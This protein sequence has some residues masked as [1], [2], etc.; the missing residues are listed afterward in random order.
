MKTSF[1]PKCAATAIGSMP[2]VDPKDA[3]SFIFS[4][5]PEMPMWPQLN[6]RSWKESMTVQFCEGMPSIVVDEENERIYF[7][8]GPEADLPGQVE[9]FYVDYLSKCPERFQIS[10]DY[11]AGLQAFL[12]TL[13]QLPQA[14]KAYLKGHV[15]GPVTFGLSVTDEN[16]QAVLYNEMLRDTV[17]KT[18]ALKAAWQVDMF[19]RARPGARAVIFFD[20]PY[21]QSF[22]SAYV[23]LSREEVTAI[24]NE[25][26][27]A[28]DG[29][30]GVHC[31]GNTDWSILM[32][33]DV[34]IISFDAYD[35]ID[36]LVLYPEKLSAFLNRG[37]ALAWGIVPSIFPDPGQVAH[38]DVGSLASRFAVGLE[39]ITA[40]GTSEELVINQSLLTPT[41]GTGSME[42]SLAERSISLTAQ[43]SQ[44]LRERYFGED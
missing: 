1:K 13:E 30:T 20:E 5:L 36:N 10:A 9:A 44:E 24:L 35:Y 11:A 38:E 17:V 25:C 3:C 37:G 8:T 43:L 42:I 12:N 2:Y 22:G 32:E 14:G 28:V 29:L 21:L 41:C 26:F 19:K 7:G 31:C 4:Q 6:K 33:T 40:M 39:K 18:L 15:V 23:S 27:A 16:K 34:D